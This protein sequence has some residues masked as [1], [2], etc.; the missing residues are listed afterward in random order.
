[1]LSSNENSH[2]EKAT[3]QTCAPP[4]EGENVDDLKGRGCNLYLLRVGEPPRFIA[5]LAPEDDNI[6]VS[7]ENAY[8]GG[9]WQLDPAFRSAEATLDGHSLVFESRRNLTGYD[10]EGQPGLTPALEV[11]VYSSESDKLSCASCLPDGEPPEGISKPDGT[12]LQFSFNSKFM[13]RWIADGGGEVFFDSKQALVPQ[14]TNG[15]TDVYEWEPEGVGSCSVGL[16][17]TVDGGCVFLLSSGSAPSDS[18]FVEASGDGSEVFFATRA[19]L[20]PQDED[21]R[22]DVYD[23]RV[24]GGF[25]RLALA[26]TGTGCQGVPPAPPVFAT[27]ASVTFAGVGNFSPPTNNPSVK[28]KTKTGGKACRRGYVKRRGKCVKSRTKVRVGRRSKRGRK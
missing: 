3:V 12:W 25:P 1:V 17:S 16:S 8:I 15:R 9:D 23:A 20:V 18:D 27:P 19:R 5:T 13:D 11:F 21:E 4:E 2:K 24:D 14:D 10:N 26:C 28:S 22:Q 7:A 6:Q